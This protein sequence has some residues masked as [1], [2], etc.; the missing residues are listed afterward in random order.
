MGSIVPSRFKVA[1]RATLSTVIV[2]GK[3]CVFKLL[4][5]SESQRNVALKVVG[6]LVALKA[7]VHRNVNSHC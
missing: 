2:D 6:I 1:L 7:I 3:H 5:S 4:S